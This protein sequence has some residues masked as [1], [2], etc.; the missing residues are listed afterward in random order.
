MS[1]GLGV[2]PPPMDPDYL[3]VG[4][5]NPQA[6]NASS[7]GSLDQVWKGSPQAEALLI[8]TS[9]QWPRTHWENLQ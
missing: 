5:E 3:S 8:E 2:Y 9:P 4:A 7:E 1:V 6:L